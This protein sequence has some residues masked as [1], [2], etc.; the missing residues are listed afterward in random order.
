MSKQPPN[1][2]LVAKDLHGLEWRFRH[3]FRGNT[4][5]FIVCDNNHLVTTWSVYSLWGLFSQP[6]SV[7]ST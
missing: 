5:L 7:F 2:E 6:F 1:Q 3:I 4:F